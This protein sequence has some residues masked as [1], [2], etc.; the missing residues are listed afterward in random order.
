MD[1]LKTFR[2]ILGLRGWNFFLFKRLSWLW[3][4]TLYIILIQE[5]FAIGFLIKLLILILGIGLSF[6]WG[7]TFNDFCDKKHDLEAGKSRKIS[8]ISENK[9]IAILSLP[10]LASLAIT[11]KILGIYFLF[12]LLGVGFTVLYSHPKTRLK[13]KGILGPISNSTAELILFLLVILFLGYY[14]AEIFVFIVLYWLVCFA[15]LVNHQIV[16]DYEFDEKGN[17][18][19]LAVDWGYE[20]SVR[21]LKKVSDLVVL[22]F[23]FLSVFL[24]LKVLFFSLVLLFLSVLYIVHPMINPEIREKF[25]VP[26][27]YVDFINLGLFGFIPLF[28]AF[29]VFV[30]YPPYSILLILIFVSEY[31]FILTS[32]ERFRDIF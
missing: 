16:E 4:A 17:V 14:G 5:K 7:M 20:A 8:K 3:P 24:I 30:E 6:F 1:H 10:L 31:R 26:L 23:V 12:H 18:Q 29:A 28:F 19:T 32:F 21:F 22:L 13:E 2:K 27:I 15:D 9:T 25:V 11:W